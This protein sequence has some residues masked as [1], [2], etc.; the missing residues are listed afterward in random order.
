MADKIFLSDEA[1]YS[2]CG[3]V[4]EQNS[5]QL[6]K[7]TGD[8]RK[9]LALKK[10]VRLVCIMV[11]GF[12]WPFFVNDQ[13]SAI[14]VDSDHR[15]RIIFGEKLKIMIWRMFFQQDAAKGH[16]RKANRAPFLEKFFM[17]LC[18]RSCLRT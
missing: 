1:H 12:Y 16:T 3:Y 14:T 2:L 17:E 6:S 13:R 7:S 15:G 10:S 5:L 8:R 11:W 4:N 18:K 9:T